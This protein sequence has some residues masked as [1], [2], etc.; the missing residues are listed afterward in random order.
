[1]KEPRAPNGFYTK[2]LHTFPPERMKGFNDGLTYHDLLKVHRHDI[3]GIWA[4][5]AFNAFMIAVLVI[6]VAGA[7]GIILY[8][9]FWQLFL[10]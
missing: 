2:P 5:K 7:L 6:C 1:M 8:G 3:R 4:A 10:S 9:A